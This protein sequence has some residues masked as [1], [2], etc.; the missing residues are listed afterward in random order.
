MIIE[1]CANSVQS[2]VNADIAGADRI[3]L[4]QNLNEGGTTPSFAAIKYCV[5]NLKLKTFVLIRPRT[6]DFHYSDLEFE[7]I[8]NDVLEC[9]RLGVSGVVVGFLNADYTIDINKTRQIVE[10]AAP[11][12]VT[13]HRAF[14]ICADPKQALEDIITSGC[15][16]ILTSGCKPTA[17]EGVENLL[18]LKNQAA[19]RIKLLVGS[20]VNSRNIRELI[21]QTGLT[22]F[23][24]SGKRIIE[25][26]NFSR[27]KEY[28]DASNWQYAETNTEEIKAMLAARE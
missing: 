8:K 11:M 4:C 24:G 16:R 18:N 1:V 19:G 21:T 13:F 6:G 7:I 10:L 17:I 5:E 3:E 12:E 20:G 15:H 23:H 2:A 25:D 26:S 14:D 9:K 22:E 28:L 27:E